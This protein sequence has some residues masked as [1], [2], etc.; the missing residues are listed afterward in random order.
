VYNDFKFSPSLLETVDICVPTQYFR[1]LSLFTVGSTRKSNYQI[2][3]DTNSL[4]TVICSS[5]RPYV[6]NQ[7]SSLTASHLGYTRQRI[8]L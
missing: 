8:K 7:C 5:A 6:L 1:D 4:N 2:L 3:N